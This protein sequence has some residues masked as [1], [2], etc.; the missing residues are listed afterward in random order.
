MPNPIL[1]PWSRLHRL[2]FGRWLYGRLL[3]LTVPYAATIRPDVRQLSPGQAE[4]RLH[5]RRRVRNHLRSIHA[6][7]LTNLAELTGNLA[8]S[9]LQPPDGRW[10]VTGM[11]TEFVKKARGTI[12]ARCTVAPPDWSRPLDLAGLVELRDAAG[13]VVMRARPRWKLGPVAPAP[14]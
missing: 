8:L 1:H 7:A 2:P 5:D 12:T 13:D 11:D 4:I 10:I 3:G 6:V 9:S 14:T